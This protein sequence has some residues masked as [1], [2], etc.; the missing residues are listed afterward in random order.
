MCP[1]KKSCEECYGTATVGEKGQVVIP[2]EAR[3]LMKLKKGDKLLVFGMGD[4]MIAFSKLSNLEK[5]ASHL[6]ERLEGIRAII[7]KSKK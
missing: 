7:N 3:E 2:R 1:Q 6:S 5:F 4:D